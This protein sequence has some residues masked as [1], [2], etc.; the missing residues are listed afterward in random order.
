MEEPKKS[1]I[2]VISKTIANEVEDENFSP[3]LADMQA[4]SSCSDEINR[5]YVEE[6]KAYQ[7]NPTSPC[8]KATALKLLKRF[9]RMEFHDFW[10]TPV[11]EYFPAVSEGTMKLCE[12]VYPHDEAIRYAKELILTLSVKELAKDFLYGVAHNAPEYRTALACYYYVKNLP[13]HEFKKCWVGQSPGK[14]G[15]MIDRYN[16]TACEVCGYNYS[17]SKEAKMQFYW[18]NTEMGKFYFDGIMN[19]SYLNT[20]IIFLEE[21]KR[22]N[23]PVHSVGDYEHFMRIVDAIESTPDN[24]TSGKLRRELKKSGLLSMTLDEIAVFIDMLGYLDILHPE[25]S[26]GMLYTHTQTKDMLHPL[27]AWGNA[28]HPVNRW[29]GKNGIDYDSISMLFDGIYD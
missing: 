2:E 28:E 8:N 1:V 21:Y 24:M 3:S 5:A 29:T 4:D 10:I 18:A 17:V 16:E 23:R 14:N 15:Q 25:D 6:I 7:A 12:R 11:R 9:A 26:H 27:S 22:L 13:E 19:R 20:A